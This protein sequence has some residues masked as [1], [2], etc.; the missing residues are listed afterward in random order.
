MCIAWG[1]DVSTE[2]AFLRTIG[3]AGDNLTP[4]L[5]FADWLDEQGT[6]GCAQSRD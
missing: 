6:G 2:A 4:R 3:A 1:N 5:V